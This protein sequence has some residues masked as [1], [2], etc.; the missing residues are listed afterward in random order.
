V[1]LEEAW[2]WQVKVYHA[3]AA[4]VQVGLRVYGYVQTSPFVKP[5]DPRGTREQGAAL[6]EKQ[7]SLRSNVTASG[8]AQ[9]TDDAAAWDAELTVLTSPWRSCVTFWQV[10]FNA[11]PE[12]GAGP[13]QP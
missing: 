4:E 9:R 3:A 1:S 11:E 13:M 10:V 12:L 8:N 5:P 7:V 2:S 6:S